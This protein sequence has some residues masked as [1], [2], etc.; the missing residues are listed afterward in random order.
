MKLSYRIAL[1]TL[2]AVMGRVFPAQAHLRAVAGAQG[3]PSNSGS[4]L[5][6]PPR[7]TGSMV[8][9]RPP[10][11]K[12]SAEL[13]L[14]HYTLPLSFELNRGQAD[15]SVKYLGRADGFLVAFRENE[16][17]FCFAQHPA[18]LKSEIRGAPSGHLGE[19]AKADLLQMRFIGA[20]GSAVVEG[21]TRLPGNVNY[22]IG[23]APSKWRRDVPTFGE[24]RYASLYPGVDLVYYG[25][26]QHLEFDFRLAPGA[27]PRRVLMDFK[28]ARRVTLDSDGDLIIAAQTGAV[29]FHKPVIYQLAAD[30]SKQMIRGSFALASHS[31]VGFRLGRYDHSRPL[32][33]DPIL[34][35]SLYFGGASD[36]AA[37][38]VNSADE[39]Y[40]TGTAA[41]MPVTPGSFQTVV[42]TKPVAY[43]LPFIAKLN[44]TGTALLYCTYISGT[45]R[46]VSSALAIDAQGD[47]YIAGQTNSLDFPI[48]QGAFQTTY[49]ATAG[50]QS[51]YS[52][53][54]AFVIELNPT[55]NALVYSTYLGGST[56]AWAVGIA[57]DSNN[58][59]YVAGATYDADFPTTASAFQQAP[60]S[61]T[62]TSG[63]VTKFNPVGSALAYSTYLHG[64]A[65]DLPAGIAIDSS[66]NVYVGGGTLSTDFATTQG[67][68][69]TTTTGD[70]WG[71]FL[72][73]LNPAGSALVYSTYLGENNYS[74]INA[75]AVDPSGN[76]YVT[77]ATYDPNFPVTPGVFQTKVG[78]YNGFAAT[79]SF[80]TKFNSTGSSLV[81]SSFLGGSYDGL[82]G[83]GE[84][85]A[86]AIA[87]D[88]NGDAI[89]TGGSGSLDFPVT[90]GAF[91]T[92][93]LALLNSA[94]GSTFLSKISPD[95]SELLYSTFLSGTGDQTGEG[96]DCANG[97][98][99]DSS[100]NVFLAGISV[101]V[102][103]PLTPGVMQTQFPGYAGAAFVTQFNAAEMITLPPPAFAISSNVESAEYG[104]P[105]T[106]TATVKGSGG[107]TPTGIVGFSIEGIEPGDSGGSGS[108]LGPWNDVQLDAS[109]TATFTPSTLD[110]GTLTVAAYYLGDSNY[111]PAMAAMTESVTTIP[112]TTTI[113]ASANPTS[114]DSSVSFTATVLD[115]TGKP[116][117]GMAWFLVGNI[118]Y[119]EP[120]LNSSGQ[121][122][123]TIDLSRYP[124]AVGA[125]TVTAQYI[126]VSPFQY[127]QTS[128]SIVETVN[129]LGAAP[130][131]TF[132]PAAGTYT[133]A[134]SVS[135][136]DLVNNATIY[137]TTDGTAPTTS[138]G[139]LYTNGQPIEVNST[140]TVQAIAIAP[141]YTV[142]SVATATYTI[143]LPA[144]GFSVT[145]TAVTV[146]PGATTGNTS[147]ISLT[148]SGGFTGAISLSCAI[149]PTAASDPATCNIPAS[150]TINGT[151]AQT[152]T[153]TVYT[154]AASSALNPAKKLL[155]PSAGGAALACIL[156][157][158]VPTRRQ[159]WQS[160]LGILVLL[161]S[162]AGG[163][164]ACGGGGN[165]GG[166]GGG[167]NPGTTPG[168]Y[169]ITVTG[170]SGAI[171]QTGTGS[172]TVQ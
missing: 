61:K 14:R 99:L 31:I 113:T 125:N 77:G 101:S 68:Y 123:W 12:S 57:V 141:G 18:N 87:V 64:S 60:A 71:A 168:A 140:E 86:T 156:F 20:N 150:I 25:A 36:A 39:V 148:P 13:K 65:Q 89:V 66:D 40:I 84:D 7:P 138:T 75:V 146:T 17:E 142:S 83:V 53:G 90:T 139:I 136:S 110:P 133:S 16:A 9:A 56:E 19:G 165:G 28:G 54:T 149:T 112:T 51:A 124:L 76:A 157:L 104:T 11:P 93:N 30:G 81:Y 160:I 115:N 29:G 103:F 82:G 72:T 131:P 23:G 55:G 58:S 10:A 97:I 162:I 153:L 164:F 154:T 74:Y 108:G 132:S 47:A 43:P 158:G 135:L 37:I 102:D 80:V 69:Q 4:L 88:G 109:G 46:D 35:Y 130:A 106:F 127:T 92:Q 161:F 145:G 3:S 147:I 42:P 8:S 144:P 163:V 27:D 143:N 169:T 171:T 100:G 59:A 94:E 151:T 50:E 155:W 22:F 119:D 6:N 170:T 5:S 2:F 96:C 67:A 33:I 167:G 117:V 15:S 116:A 52:N 111:A 79:D 166:V 172:L 107:A 128:A 95:A 78:E 120:T 85:N 41:Q 134:Q 118:V 91:E 105:V 152:T 32:V 137:Y 129:S 159:R 44:S 24:V 122:T 1:F 26:E 114:Y 126:D 70:N 38:A 121:A 45:N 34:N 62:A 98:A 48:T 73:K 49:P 21:W 63:F